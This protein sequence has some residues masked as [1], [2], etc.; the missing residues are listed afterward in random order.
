MVQSS[1]EAY[2]APRVC[3]TLN[4]KPPTLPLDKCTRQA[5]NPGCSACTNTICPYPQHHPSGKF[6]PS[7]L[8]RA[9]RRP[10]ISTYLID[11]QALRN[12]FRRSSPYLPQCRKYNTSYI[13]R[14]AWEPLV[15]GLRHWCQKMSGLVHRCGP[16]G[17]QQRPSVAIG[18]LKP[19]L[20]P[21][22]CCPSTSYSEMIPCI[23]RLLDPSVVR[24]LRTQSRSHLGIVI[25]CI[26]RII[27]TADSLSIPADS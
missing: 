9:L 4:I 17:T 12:H 3:C 18:H 16:S 8:V 2:P 7:Q 26:I 1:S 5:M 6:T 15:W 22:S 14:G 25:D 24:V 20:K 19:T 23:I 27:R 11:G 13:C 10:L 21:G